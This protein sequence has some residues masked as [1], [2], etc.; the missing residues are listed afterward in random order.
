[1]SNPNKVFGEIISSE[2]ELKELCE[3]ESFDSMDVHIRLGKA[4]EN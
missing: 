4:P 2:I 1:M 3:V